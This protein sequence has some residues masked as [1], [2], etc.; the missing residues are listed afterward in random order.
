MSEEKFDLEAFAINNIVKE[1]T[2]LDEPARQ[3]VFSY[4]KTRFDIRLDEGNVSLPPD[5]PSP[6]QQSSALPTQHVTDIRTLKEQKDPKNDSEMAA[7]VGYYLKKVAPL[8][9]RKDIITKEDIEKYFVQ[10]G[11]ELPKHARMTLPVAKDAGYFDQISAG[12][13]KLNPVGHN[14]ITHYLPGREK[15]VSRSPSKKS[16]KKQVQLKKKQKGVKSKK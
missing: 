10:A 15:V 12:K 1:L 2:P 4:I 16:K 8:D 9:E 7:I 13:Y 6:P 11:F 14:L 3:R 5:V